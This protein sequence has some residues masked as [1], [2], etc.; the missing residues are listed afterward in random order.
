LSALSPEV[1]NG[2]FGK[3]PLPD[4]LLMQSWVHILL[5]VSSSCV[6]S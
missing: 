4:Q 6:W 1:I 5:L 3:E 2:R